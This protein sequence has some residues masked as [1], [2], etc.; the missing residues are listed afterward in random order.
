MAFQEAG[1]YIDERISKA[2]RAISSIPLSTLARAALG[3]AIVGGVAAY[4]ELNQTPSSTEPNNSPVAAA[5]NPDAGTILDPSLTVVV[6]RPLLPQVAVPTSVATPILAEASIVDN[7][8]LREGIGYQDVIFAVS[9][10]PVD[11][12]DP[13]TFANA[14]ICQAPIGLLNEQGSTLIARIVHSL[15]QEFVP[16]SAEAAENAAPETKAE[17]LKCMKEVE[18]A[19]PEFTLEGFNVQAWTEENVI[20]AKSIADWRTDE[21]AIDLK[22][23]GFSVTQAQINGFLGDRIQT[24]YLKTTKDPDTGKMVS[25]LAPFTAII[26]DNPAISGKGVYRTS[27]QVWMVVAP[28]STGKMQLLAVFKACDN[29]F[30]ETLPLQ[31]V[32]NTPVPS[33]SVPST[34]VPAVPSPVPP[35]ETPKPTVLPPTAPPAPTQPPVAT[36]TE[37]P[38]PPPADTATP[39]PTVLP[40]TAPP[41]PTQP[42]VATATERPTP[43]PADTATPKPTVLPPTAP[44]APTQLPVATATPRPTVLPPT[45]TPIKTGFERPDY[46]QDSIARSDTGP[47]YIYDAGF[48]IENW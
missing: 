31:P 40:P 20:D 9:A 30:G 6:R 32:E 18:Q 7:S 28:D 41:A 22:N 19:R 24:V 33:T 14:G 23:R 16:Q 27:E 35:I 34:P 13:S 42:P 36:A 8:T 48:T 26:T 25:Q 46:F 1:K 17:F 10:A 15:E 29:A 47:N 45:S 44:P 21:L 43:P 37:R 5:G 3:T 4:I 12:S 38:T 2:A 39:K 11:T